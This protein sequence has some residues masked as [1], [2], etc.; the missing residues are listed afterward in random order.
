MNADNT[1][2]LSRQLADLVEHNRSMLK[3][4]ESGDWNQVV[5]AE[6]GRRRM[7]EAFYSSSEMHRVPDVNAATEEMLSINK[8]LERLALLARKAATEGVVLINKGRRAVNAYG[9]HI[10]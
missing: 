2:D 10:R 4:A 5:E 9:K 8:E 1:H 7:L 6:A 3:N